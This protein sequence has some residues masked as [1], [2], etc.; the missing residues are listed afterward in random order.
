MINRILPSQSANFYNNCKI[1]IV[2]VLFLAACAPISEKTQQPL[3]EDTKLLRDANAML[4][5]PEIK[6]KSVVIP[7]FEQACEMGNNYGCHMI[8]T[9]YYNGLQGKPKDYNEAKKWYL[10]AANRGY[11]PSQLNIANLYAHRLLPLDDETGFYWLA[12]AQ[13][14]LQECQEGSVE[15]DTKVSDSER[16]R[17]CR[18][19]TQFYRKVRGIFRKRMEGETMMRIEKSVNTS[20]DN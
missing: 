14:G 2:L 1:F 20:S 3:S 13:K 19:A 10:R 12:K 9:A 15:S 17:M 11:V 6:D 16:R 5:N 18:L 4:S 8:G 7:K